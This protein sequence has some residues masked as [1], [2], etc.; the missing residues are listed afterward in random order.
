MDRAAPSINLLGAVWCLQRS[1]QRLRQMPAHVVNVA[2]VAGTVALPPG[3]YSAT[4]HALVAFSPRAGRLARGVH[5][6]T[7]NPGL[8]ETPGFPQRGRLGSRLLER[9]VEPG[10]RRPPDRLGRRAQPARDL[11]PRLVSVPAIAQAL[12]PGLVSRLLARRR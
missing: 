11:C 9:T 8:V 1:Y 10:V 5:V 7:V 12:A 3:L 4:K 2:S 6:H